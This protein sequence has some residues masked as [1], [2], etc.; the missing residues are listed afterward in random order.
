MR[1]LLAGCSASISNVPRVC[2][3]KGIECVFAGVVLT[4]K[5]RVHFVVF[6]TFSSRVVLGRPVLRWTSVGDLLSE[7]FF[8][9]NELI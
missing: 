3:R 7:P 1:V 4:K 2:A 6:S 9:R 5:N 8:Y